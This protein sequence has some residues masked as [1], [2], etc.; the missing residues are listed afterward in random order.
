MNSR[1]KGTLGENIACNFLI[2][3]GFTILD[4]NYRKKWGEI[5]I[6]G[7]KDNVFHFIEVKSALCPCA[8]KPITD[9]HTPEENV[10]GFKLRQISRMVDTYFMERKVTCETAFSFHVICVFMDMNERKARIKWIKDVVL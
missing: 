5:D 9:W 3:R 6:V 10:D 8:G 4:R 2:K 7:K 1:Q